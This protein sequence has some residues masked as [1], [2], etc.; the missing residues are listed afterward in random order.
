MY[1]SPCVAI[2]ASDGGVTLYYTSFSSVVQDVFQH[3]LTFLWPFLSAVLQGTK[4]HEKPCVYCTAFKYCV[5]IL[6]EETGALQ[7]T[8]RRVG[9][10]KAEPHFYV[11][12][13]LFQAQ[14][15]GTKNPVDWSLERLTTRF[16]VSCQ[17]MPV[18]SNTY[19]RTVL[20]SKSFTPFVVA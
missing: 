17:S 1:G 6:L 20:C 5:K 15:C 7:S 3:F 9:T 16:S 19:E 4:R 12:R 14:I 18:F 11:Y 10:A 2:T 8:W 13:R